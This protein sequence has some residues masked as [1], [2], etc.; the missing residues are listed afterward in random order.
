MLE[1]RM[2][3]ANVLTSFDIEFAEAGQLP[4]ITMFWMLDHIDFKV[5]FKDAHIYKHI[6]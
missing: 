2:L 4:K 6:S 1:I 3:L 5:R